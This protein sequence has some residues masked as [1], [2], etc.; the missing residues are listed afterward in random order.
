MRK[1]G[2]PVSV[3]AAN[4]A[5]GREIAMHL[6]PLAA[7][8]VSTSDPGSLEPSGVLVL[9][10][11]DLGGPWFVRT[12]GLLDRL[13]LWNRSI[14][15]TSPSASAILELGRRPPVSVV[16][17][18]EL[19]LGHLPSAVALLAD[20]AGRAAA[21]RRVA[22]LIS[23][24]DP[25]LMEA[26]ELA[27]GGAEAITSVSAL[28]AQ[29]YCV[30]TTLRDRWRRGQLPGTPKDLL[31]HALALRLA[32]G[33]EDGLSAEGLARRH[34]VSRS[35]CYRTMRRVIGHD[36]VEPTVDVVW[37]SLERWAT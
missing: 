12:A 18:S 13:D 15:V 20:G 22:S 26:V 21:A 32:E 23:T 35:T 24:K 31:D 19:G 17:I 16:L 30:P 29:L 34:G 36:D 3:L 11:R 14:L 7:S 27:F 2:C 28:A 25:L 6:S 8:I 9:G 10:S 33:R 4:R 5:L 1:L 37:A